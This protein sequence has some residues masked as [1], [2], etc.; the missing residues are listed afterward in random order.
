[1][2]L[3]LDRAVLP[4][5]VL[6]GRLL[7]TAAGG[8]LDGADVRARL[9]L[10]DGRLERLS[11]DRWLGPVTAADEIVAG[12]AR[13]A[14]LDVG[15]GPGR[16]LEALTARGKTALGVDL[17]PVAVQ[18]ARRR[19]GTAV[20]GSIFAD[21]PGAGTWGSA[22]LLDGNIGIGGDPVA[23]LGRLRELLAPGG[24]VI[25]EV[26]PPGAA[27]LV[28]R[29]RLESRGVVS[30][31]FAWA[32]VSADAIAAHAARAGFAC[33]RIAPVH[34]RWLAELSWE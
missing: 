22:L 21:V 24:T 19:G 20:T 6:Y 5:D 15:C 30:A 2:S 10:A 17:S 1:M 16:L 27:T 28:E 4:A 29:M 14:V 18:L 26:D 9:R 31:W 12:W 7:A 3:A 8:G 13:P 25:A 23:L 32:R 11:L 33:A 34:G